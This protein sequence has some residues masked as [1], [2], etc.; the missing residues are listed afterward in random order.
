MA[1][2]L[3]SPINTN[4]SLSEGPLV[5]ESCLSRYRFSSGLNDRLFAQAASQILVGENF[6]LTSALHSIAAGGLTGLRQAVNDP[7]RTSRCPQFGSG[8]MCAAKPG[9]MDLIPV[10]EHVLVGNGD[11]LPDASAYDLLPKHR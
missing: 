10:I 2:R 7:M 9:G 8:R 4:C 1:G 5:A 6:G 3:T 11:I